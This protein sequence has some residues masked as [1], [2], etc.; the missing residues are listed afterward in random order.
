MVF[1]IRIYYDCEFLDTGTVIYL[2]SIGL[3]AENGEELYLVNADAPWAQIRKHQWLMDNV[4]PSLPHGGDEG[5]RNRRRMVDFQ[6][7]AVWSKEA[8]A[9]E[10]AEFILDTPD[11][12]LWAYYAA[13]D[14]VVL[15]QLWGPLGDAPDGIP[16]RTNDLEQELVRL[17]NPPV[18][19]QTEGQ[20]HA[21]FDARWNKLVY[22]TIIETN[23]EEQ[24][25]VA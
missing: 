9:A 14:H 2:I 4:M 25:D 10:V 16:Q 18:P 8:I 21:L 6:D 12:E 1:K 19:E 20:H 5:W 7:P 23:T 22:E 17:G 24:Q 11:P 3:V 15:T 13:Y